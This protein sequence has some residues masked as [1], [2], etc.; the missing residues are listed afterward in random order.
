MEL[1]E[2]QPGMRVELHPGTSFWMMGARYGEVIKIGPRSGHIHV[3]LDATGRTMAFHPLN[4][5]RE[6]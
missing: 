4:I 5:L 6:V 3:K 2:L 1:S